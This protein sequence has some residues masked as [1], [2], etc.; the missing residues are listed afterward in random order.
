MKRSKIESI[1]DILLIILIF[2]VFYSLFFNGGIFSKKS[3]KI[4]GDTT[5][6][7]T[8]VKD[9]NIIQNIS[10][11]TP[12]IY[13]KENAISN[14]SLLSFIKKFQSK[15]ENVIVDT[16]CKTIRLYNDTLQNDTNA[17]VLVK[18]TI[19][20]QIL[21]RSKYIKTYSTTINT[22]KTIKIKEKYWHLHVG[23]YMGKDEF[24]PTLIYTS[25]KN[26]EIG[27]GYNILESQ[28]RLY[29]GLQLR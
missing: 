12:N 17:F 29:I 19:Q 27:G 15:N 14:D 8:I 16:N 10:R 7:T 25:K 3:D 4:T 21:G 26:I 6:I 23:A 1:K 20:G 18:D 22:E 28:P 13:I 11:P 9:T 24:S 2:F 5:I